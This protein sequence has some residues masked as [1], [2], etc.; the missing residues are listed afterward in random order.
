MILFVKVK[1][2]G[3]MFCWFFVLVFVISFF[4]FL[5]IRSVLVSDDCWCVRCCLFGECFIVLYVCIKG[6]NDFNFNDLVNFEC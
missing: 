4:V 3:S 6:S 1:R 2:I 5:L